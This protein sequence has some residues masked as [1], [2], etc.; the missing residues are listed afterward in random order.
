MVVPF[1][2]VNVLPIHLV[3]I[4]LM[5]HIQMMS[6]HLSPPYLQ[7]SFRIFLTGFLA[8]TVLPKSMTGNKNCHTPMVR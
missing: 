2:V 7:T 8:N 4:H 3:I 5:I 6:I 1:I